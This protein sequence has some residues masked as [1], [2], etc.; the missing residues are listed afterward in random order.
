[1]SEGRLIAVSN[2]LP[3]TVRRQRS[4]GW[5]VEHSSGGLS[6]AMRPILKG[7]D[8]LWIGWPGEGPRVPDPE[9]DA[10]MVDWR[11]KYG[12]VIVD[13][14]PAVA[15]KF[16]EGYANQTLW[17]LFHQFTTWFD[18]EAE[19][20]AAY[21]AANRRFRDVVLEHYRPGDRVWVHDYHLMLLPRM[22]RDVE[23]EVRC[24]FF[25]HIPFPAPEVFRALPHRDEILQGLLGADLTCFQTHNDL[26][27]FRT[28]L[29]RVLGLQS[30]MD[31]VVGRG[32][33]TRL[34][35]L[36]IGIAPEEFTGT[37]QNDAEAKET[38]DSLRRRFEGNRILL[39]VDRLDYT[40]GIPNRLRAFRQLLAR[41]PQLRGKVVLIQVAVPSR[42]RIAH[43]E[44]LRHQVSRLVGEV[45]GEFSTP[46][47]TPVVYMRRGLSRAELVA[48]Y[49]AADVAWVT[50]LR[51]GMNLVAKEY[52]ACQGDGAGALL[53]SEFAGAAAEMG[54]AFLVNPYDEERVAA[55]LERILEMPEAERRERMGNLHRRVLRNDVFNWS[56]RFLFELERAALD[57][58]LSPGRPLALP[59]PE[60]VSAFHAARSRLILVDYDGTLVPFAGT[61]GEAVPTPAVLELLASLVD[62]PGTTTVVVS[63]RSRADLDGWLGHIPGLWMVA[64]HGAVVRCPDSR[65]WESARP[66]PGPGW[67]AQVRPVLERYLDRT[68]GSLIEEKELSL[69]W[70]HRLSEPEFGEWVANELVVNLETMLA[71]T[72]LRAVRGQK[73]V[74]VRFA[75]ASKGAVMARLFALRPDAAF[76]LAIGDD[77]T[78]EDM[79]EHMAPHDWSVRVGG[80]PSSARYSLDDPSE[81]VQLLSVL[82]EPRARPA[83]STPAT[84]RATVA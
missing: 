74:E 14:P 49:A 1:M 22:L 76:R 4:G 3:L 68:P 69:V 62:L 7:R 21:V 82:L 57:R 13:L 6:S 17:P 51:D 18:Y 84:D 64:E 43:Y 79:F 50:P 40:K 37:L 30:R 29:T 47:W 20:W 52:V 27:H 24:G 77:R 65:I 31:R 5:K 45:N 54:E 71:D 42:E 33:A 15:R 8:G 34:E 75:W 60:L 38:L 28:S 81:V 25:L 78:D 63:G 46:D 9:R 32:Y 73:T 59:V 39:A 2:R 72:E 66:L 61:P 48:L 70:H 41:A 35:A 12:Y 55:V 16:Y 11:E 26:Q 44:E 53:L 56:E 83:D 23:P 58:G 36:P 67:K 80:G 10:L 19:G